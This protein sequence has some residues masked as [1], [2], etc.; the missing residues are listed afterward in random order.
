LQRVYK[1]AVEQ[2]I[3]AIREE[4]A[5]ATPDHSIIAWERWEQSA[6][7]AP[8]AQD[9]AAVARKAYRDGLRHLDYGI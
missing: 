1:D 4:E 5:L 3:V 9:Q 2:W 7:K 8:E 6:F